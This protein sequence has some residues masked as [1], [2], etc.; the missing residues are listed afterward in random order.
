[1]LNI[2]ENGIPQNRLRVYIV[3]ILKEIDTG[4]FEW[5]DDIMPCHTSS[6][7]NYRDK[8]LACT[9]TLNEEANIAKK[10]VRGFTKALTQKGAAP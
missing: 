1:M 7:L 8:Y 6:L 2:A 4:T 3:G 5:P 9:G 10:N